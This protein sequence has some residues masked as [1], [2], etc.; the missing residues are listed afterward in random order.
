M[1]SRFSKLG[2]GEEAGA[3]A[4]LSCFIKVRQSNLVEVK[5]G[6]CRFGEARPLARDK[7]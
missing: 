4:A 7:A 6:L 3:E 1:K 2:E 5:K